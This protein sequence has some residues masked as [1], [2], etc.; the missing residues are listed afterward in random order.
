MSAGNGKSDDTIDR[1]ISLMD[2]GV[3]AVS[4]R[5]QATAHL[6]ARE[7]SEQMDALIAQVEMLTREREAL[8]KA[9]DGL[10]GQH[11]TLI[12]TVET[13]V[14]RSNAMEFDMDMLSTIDREQ[15]K[16]I[17]AIERGAAILSAWVRR[18]FW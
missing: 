1:L 9:V 15:Q 7:R 12:K 2:R 8:V 4:Q 10:M 14:N 6:S 3:G 5:Y 17:D 18:P 13:L 11:T 16:R